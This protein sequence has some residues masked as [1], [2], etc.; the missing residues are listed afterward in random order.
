MTC[1][2]C[3][4]ACPITHDRSVYDPVVFFRLLNLGRQDEI[5]DSPSLW[6]CLECQACTD[7]CTQQVP[8]HMVIRALQEM[9]MARG[10]A[11]T[12]MRR[13]L[14]AIEHALLPRYLDEVDALFASEGRL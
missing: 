6:L 12:D 9:S 3:T 14:W 1:G 11:P 4:S 5:L 13:R 10:L 8:G 7:A 2:A